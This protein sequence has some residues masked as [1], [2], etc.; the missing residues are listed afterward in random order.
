MH[1][2]TGGWGFICK[3]KAEVFTAFWSGAGSR[4]KASVNVSA[5]RKSMGH[6]PFNERS[7]PSFMIIQGYVISRGI[8]PA[9]R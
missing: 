3:S 6:G 2:Q 7:R 1:L 9:K 5:M 8:R 4:A